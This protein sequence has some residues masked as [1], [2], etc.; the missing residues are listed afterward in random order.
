MLKATDFYAGPIDGLWTDATE[1]ALDRFTYENAFFSKPTVVV[2][3]VRKVDGPLARWML[4][5]H[6]DTLLHAPR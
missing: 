4:E 2:D 3:G 1:A 6:P 5:A